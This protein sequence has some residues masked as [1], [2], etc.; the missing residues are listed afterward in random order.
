MY[1]FPLQV[2]HQFI[3]Y[4]HTT[5]CVRFI[6]SHFCSLARIIYLIESRSRLDF[7]D[8][9]QASGHG[10]HELICAAESFRIDNDM[11]L[12]QSSAFG[13]IVIHGAYVTAE[14]NT[15][16]NSEKYLIALIT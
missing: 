10:L 6:H 16:Q 3:R 8:F 13:Q 11:H 12:T 2:F 5:G 9:V 1:R 4:V 14:R 7:A 15:Q